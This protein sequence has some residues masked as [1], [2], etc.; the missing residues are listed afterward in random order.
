[1][2]PNNSRGFKKAN[3]ITIS[4]IF[5]LYNKDVNINAMIDVSR[6]SESGSASAY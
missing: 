5:S 1:M 4:G 6:L 3:L 2:K